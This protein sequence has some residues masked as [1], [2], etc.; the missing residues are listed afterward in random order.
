MPA[1]VT[2]LVGR[3][4]TGKSTFL[5]NRL[6]KAHKDNLVLFDIN[7]EHKELYPKPLMYFDEFTEHCTNV[8]NA[9]IAIEE[10]TVFL[11]NRGNNEDVRNFLARA[12]HN[13]C[14]VFI[15]FHSFRA[16]PGYIYDL[17]DLI[18]VFKTNDQEDLIQKKFGDPNLTAAFL[19]IKESD[20]KHA[21][22]IH[23]IYG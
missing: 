23:S 21:F 22:K 20:N 4:K 11:P 18:V 10:G 7:G 9:L 6:K 8:R 1:V 5:K 15:V 12:R 17:A 19:A 2:L 14:S 16:V 13:N 3:R